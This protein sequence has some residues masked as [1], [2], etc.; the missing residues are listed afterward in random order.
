MVVT[1]N[2]STKQTPQL[3]YKM[4]AKKLHWGKTN[5]AFPGGK[6]RYPIELIRHYQIKD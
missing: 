1:R 6:H 2:N 4:Q 5:L 3:F